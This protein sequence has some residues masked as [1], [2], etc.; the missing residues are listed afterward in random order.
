MWGVVNHYDEAQMNVRDSYAYLNAFIKQ[1]SIQLGKNKRSL[2]SIFQSMHDLGFE[3]ISYL[4]E[5]P[6]SSADAPKPS[7]PVD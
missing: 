3:R 7:E 2:T 1:C 4:G 6:S 5:L